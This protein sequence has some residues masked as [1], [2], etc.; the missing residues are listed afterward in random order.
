VIVALRHH[1]GD[2]TPGTRHHRAFSLIELM[3]AIV[4]L[5]L[6]MVM[7]ATM[8]PVAWGRARD[9]SEFTSH[10]SIGFAASNTT[11]R[12]LRAA[13]A[14]LASAQAG[15]S[16]AGDLIYY[17]Y[18]GGGINNWLAVDANNW[19][20]TTWVHALNMENI[21]VDNPAF[22]AEDPW[23]VE[24]GFDLRDP[25]L[26]LPPAV[27][28]NS[29][30]TSYVNAQILVHQR[31]YPP[32]RRRQFITR[33]RRT[34]QNYNNK[35]GGPGADS[36]VFSSTQTDALWDNAVASRRFCWAVFH[37]MRERLVPPS[38]AL[39][40]ETRIYDLYY[41]T[42]R[43]PQPTNRYAR[44]ETENQDNLPNPRDIMSP[45]VTPQAMPPDQDVMLPVAWRVQVEFPEELRDPSDPD[46]PSAPTEIMVP[47]S[48][49]TGNDQ[50]RNML[51][52]M[53]PRGT[54][55]IDEITGLVYR[56]TQV[57][58]VLDDGNP[59]RITAYLTLDREVLLEDVD[60]KPFQGPPN[61]I[62]DARCDTCDAGVYDDPAERVRTVWVFPPPV[63]EREE[64]V[65]YPAFSGSTPVV[66]INIRSLAFTPRR[67]E[68]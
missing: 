31:F 46:A 10:Q 4:I 15:P 3:V 56:V 67:P 23:R 47:P 44:Q 54:Q 40:E 43:R 7:V 22:V 33:P 12:L 1:P 68:P 42:L 58:D 41:V 48:A 30:D 49:F 27:I 65:I 57:R 13:P 38:P 51:V 36:G 11:S 35:N 62:N 39:A 14:D 50:A 55:F 61:A 45:P 37:R 24:R 59:D 18:G 9:L 64:G 63:V 17:S 60:L 52:T 8:F 32:M 26:N 34:E 53:F 25:N 28:A 19:P 29:V 20:N 21:R 2:T 16:F 66:D 5:G 6:G